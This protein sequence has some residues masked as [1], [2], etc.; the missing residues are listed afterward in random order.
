MR[1][2]TGDAGVNGVFGFS[3]GFDVYSD[4]VPPFSGLDQSAP[5]ALDWLQT[6]KDRKFFLFLHGYDFHGQYVP[7]GGFDRRYADPAYNGPYDGSA[8]QQAVLREEGLLKGRL[9]VTPGDVS[10]WRA[11]YDEK[12]AR[13]D[14]RLSAFMAGF[15]R[16]EFANKTVFVILADHGTEVF[17]PGRVDHGAALYDELVRVPLLF[18][19]PGAA[20]GV[21]KGQVSTL[22]LMPTILDLVGVRAGRALKEQM[23]DKSLAP[24]IKKNTGAGRDVF[25]ETDYRL[26][27][28]KRAVSSADG[29]KFIL[30][31]ET[32]QTE[33]YDL[34]TDPGEKKNLAE[35]EPGR[36]AGLLKKLASVYP[37]AAQKG[38]QWEPGCSPVYSD[39]CR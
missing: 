6:V 32:G 39:Q 20:P 34:N 27:T 14:E 24:L 4:S 8:A 25:M 22:S 19:V 1:Q 33:L 17:E 7:P 36:A 23:D 2:I 13:A 16:T 35:S 11:V 30:T 3:A 38:G 15:G 28:H 29:W 37:E 18:I 26:Y 10:F 5:K 21:V 9:E 31:L 12:I